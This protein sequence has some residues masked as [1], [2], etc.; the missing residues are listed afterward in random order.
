MPITLTR[1]EFMVGCS[2]AI[3]AMAGARLT[4]VAFADPNSPNAYSKEIL[5]AVFLRGGWDALNVVPPIAGADRGHY[6]AARAALKVPA[7]GQGAALPLNGQ[8]GL[9][10]AMAP[11]YSLYQAQK[12]AVIH[13]CGL[14]NDTRSHFD[15]MQYIELGTPGNKN[16]ATGWITR[17]LQTAP[18]L[19]PA[20]L[21]PAVSS[22]GTQPTSLLGSTE[23]VSM[24]SPGSF[25]FGGHWDY[26]DH[27]RV[28]LRRV[29]DGDT[30]L[31][32]AGSR[33]LDAVDIVESADPGTYYPSNG[34][35]YPGGSF[36]DSLK[37]I[38]QMIKMDLGM[39]VATVDLG[40][41]DTHDFQGDGSGGYFSDL[42][43]T[44]A[45]GLAALYL[46]LDGSGCASY[47]RRL[48]VIVVSE[49]GR[50][51]RENAAHGTDHGHGSVML[52]LG[53]RVKGGKVYGAWPGLHT[54]QLYDHA[55]L[56]VTTDYRR[57]L[58]EILIGRLGNPNISTVFPGYSGFTPLGFVMEPYAPPVPVP[59]G[60]NNKVYLPLINREEADMCP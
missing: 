15:A 50:R 35:V 33:T 11:L 10:P 36:G 16:T 54:D 23:A 3:A 9:H 14:D 5:V 8:L 26:R 2:A 22:G 20:V 29:Y 37:A 31:F 43:E 52:A 42:L 27:Q 39:H 30:W 45:Q 25:E 58:S 44:L 4:H 56:A 34:A 47:S 17:H 21:I 19:P 51:L 60:L 59:P 38:A 48:T 41:W 53:G 32:Q 13:A 6:E 55:D 28:A 1:R 12:L 40:G 18:N 46:D 57:V 7:T 49:F 24:T